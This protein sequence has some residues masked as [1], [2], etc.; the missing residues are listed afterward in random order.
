MSNFDKSVC[1]FGD[2]ASNNP[3]VEE[4]DVCDPKY[5]KYEG[6]H[7]YGKVCPRLVGV[8]IQTRNITDIHARKFVL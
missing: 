1:N 8:V 4:G 7:K 6:A 3:R 2:D 5:A